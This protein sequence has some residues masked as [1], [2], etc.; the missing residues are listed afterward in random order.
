MTRIDDA[1]FAGDVA[2]SLQ[3]MPSCS[4]LGKSAGNTQVASLGDHLIAVACAKTIFV[5]DVRCF[6]TTVP[7]FVLGRRHQGGS[8]NTKHA[9]RELSLLVAVNRSTVNDF[10]SGG[11]LDSSTTIAQVAHG[12]GVQQPLRSGCS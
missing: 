7:C 9:W 4:F 11:V 6:A 12:R 5:L 8:A 10:F 1:A 3:P 2:A